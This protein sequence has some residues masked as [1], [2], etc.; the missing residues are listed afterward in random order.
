MANEAVEKRR[1]LDAADLQTGDVIVQAGL[2]KMQVVDAP[3][4]VARDAG[5]WTFSV[6]PCGG[7]MSATVRWTVPSDEQYLIERHE[8]VVPKRR[9]SKTWGGES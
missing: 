9:A 1:W 7:S 8:D 2:P 6:A 5:A 3:Q 4:M